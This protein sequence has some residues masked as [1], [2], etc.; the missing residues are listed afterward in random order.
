MIVVDTNVIA[1]LWIPGEFTSQAE[2]A[3]KK[4]PDWVAPLLWRSEFR[5]VLAIYLQRKLMTIET[6]LAL[7]S[8]TENYFRG[9][10]YAVS[11]EQVLLLAQESSCSA[12]DCEFVTLAKDLDLHL[13]T[14]DKKILKT[15]PHIATTL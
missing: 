13:L 15:F 9:K 10:E 1:Y 3:F 14:T 5:N 12:Y 4:D 11:S 7:V 6:A 2:K 8:E